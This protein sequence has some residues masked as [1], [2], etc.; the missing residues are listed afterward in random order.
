QDAYLL[1]VAADPAIGG[2]AG[3]TGWYPID[4]EVPVQAEPR[5]GFA[6]TGWLGE[7]VSDP[8]AAQS[9]VTLDR[10]RTV[11][12]VFERQWNL[13][14][15]PAEEEAGTT[16]GSSPEPIGS[17]VPITATPNEGY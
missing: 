5:E 2:S 16:T 13:I 6:W 3:Q 14:V 10:N 8:P 7:G 12:A 11:T 4:A 1:T 17:S 15:L 9:T